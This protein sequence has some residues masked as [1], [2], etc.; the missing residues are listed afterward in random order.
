MYPVTRSTLK[1]DRQ[2]RRK[3]RLLVLALT[4]F[5]IFG[6]SMA[7]NSG[8]ASDVQEYVEFSVRPGDTLWNIARIHS[9]ANMDIREYIYQ[10]Q[11]INNVKNSIIYP[12][13]I[14]LLP[15]I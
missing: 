3:K 13:D 2:N 15:I 1:R 12:G 11:V 6:L 14:L 10:I 4:A 8:G 9:P 7:F 5:I